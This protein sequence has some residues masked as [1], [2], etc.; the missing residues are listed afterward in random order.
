MANEDII[1][2]ITGVKDTNIMESEGINNS[3]S[4]LAR[5]SEE[6][7]VKIKGIGRN[8]ARK[9]LAAFELGKRLFDENHKWISNDL[10]S[11]IALYQHL[12]TRMENRETEC[13]YIV[14]MNSNF[15][16]LATIKISEGG[17]SETSMDV[18]II[19]KEVLLH[20]GTVLAVAHNHPCGNPNPS[21]QDNILTAQIAEACKCMRVFFM[22][23]II[24]GDK[25][26]YSYHDKG[27][28]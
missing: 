10:G 16:E 26:Y 20:N 28:L 25:A 24:I 11:S 2:T 8:K 7:L 6:E 22:D 3:L 9:L 21:K 5:M 14:I 18:R 13:T 23:H 4:L 27:K 19:L 17:I 1:R 12:R 15:K